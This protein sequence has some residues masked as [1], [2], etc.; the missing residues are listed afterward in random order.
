MQF[1]FDCENLFNTDAHGFVI[2]RGKELSNYAGFNTY[3][4]NVKFKQGQKIFEKGAD[5]AMDKLCSIIDR[6]GCA[7]AT[8]FS[9]HIVSKLASDD[10]LHEQ[11]RWK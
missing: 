3:N 10:N 8:V 6:M 9:T 1:P 4:S 11:I 2:L 5:S 7:S